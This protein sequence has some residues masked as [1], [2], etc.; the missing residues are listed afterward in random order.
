MSQKTV[1]IST[2][3]PTSIAEK[4]MEEINLMMLNVMRHMEKANKSML[5][6]MKY[7]IVEI[8]KIK[9]NESFIAKSSKKFSVMDFMRRRE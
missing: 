7:M 5:T 4:K 8:N 1:E 2:T 6:T 9:L 3:H